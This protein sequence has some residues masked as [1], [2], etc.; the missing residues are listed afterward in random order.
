MGNSLQGGSAEHALGRDTPGSGQ[1][2]REGALPPEPRSSG[3]F[4]LPS[5]FIARGHRMTLGGRLVPRH[6]QSPL[7]AHP[8]AATSPLPRAP[9]PATCL[10]PRV[11][12]VTLPSP[13][14]RDT[15]A[16]S[17]PAAGLRTPRE[18]DA[19]PAKPHATRRTRSARSPAHAPPAAPH[20]AR[21]RPTGS[22]AHNPA[23]APQRAPRTAPH[24]HRHSPSPRRAPARGAAAAAP[25]DL[26]AGRGRARSRQPGRTEGHAGVGRP[27]HAASEGRRRGAAAVPAAGE[28]GNRAEP[29]V[30]HRGREGKV[31][32]RRA[33]TRVLD[34]GVTP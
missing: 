27:R 15:A 10:L 30:A 26:G 16:F 7:G 5:L 1:G 4:S 31:G 18:N 22:S 20:R 9:F 3:P 12:P 2:S 25:T 19:V 23:H 6:T 11:R 33:E 34:V 29:P 28:R 32:S 14:Q 17:P 21:T 8:A 24:T 13:R